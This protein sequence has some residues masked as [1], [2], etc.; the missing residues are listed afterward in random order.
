MPEIADPTSE[1]RSEGPIDR[2]MCAPARDVFVSLAWPD[3]IFYF[4]ALTLICI[5]DGINFSFTSC[6]DAVLARV[7]AEKRLALIKAWEESEK[8]KA[9]NK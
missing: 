5:R 9:E 8:T 2:G 6:L 1:K 4:Y 3:R 7:E